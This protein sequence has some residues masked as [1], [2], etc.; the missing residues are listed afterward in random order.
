M[1]VPSR[2]GKL[3]T[4]CPICLNAPHRPK[5]L[6]KQDYCDSCL[7][8]LTRTSKLGPVDRLPIAPESIVAGADQ[9]VSVACPFAALGCTHTGLSSVLAKHIVACEYSA[10]LCDKCGLY[11]GKKGLEEH[12]KGC[13]VTCSTCD[14]SH[15]PNET[16]L[17]KKYYCQFPFDVVHT[18]KPQYV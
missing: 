17:H 13:W 4:P 7:S 10:L 16:E 2:V 15:R 3:A 5:T 6:H 8:V 11:V 9:D 18:I 12:Q 1:S 14:K